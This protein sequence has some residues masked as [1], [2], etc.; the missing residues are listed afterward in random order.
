M[1]GRSMRRGKITLLVKALNRRESEV[2]LLLKAN[3]RS[4]KY[5][6]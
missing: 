6:S 5:L 4:A 2:G 3:S 1:A